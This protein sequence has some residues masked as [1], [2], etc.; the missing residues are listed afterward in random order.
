MSDN[1]ENSSVLSLQRQQSTAMPDLL[2]NVHLQ[3]EHHNVRAGIEVAMV[4]GDYL[5][6]HYL[7][8]GFD[9]VGWGCAYRSCQTLLS[10]VRL[11][12][13]AG[14]TRNA[15][16]P[17]PPQSPQPSSPFLP[18]S[19]TIPSIHELQSQLHAAG[20]KSSSF[21]GSCEWIG[22]CEVAL[23]LDMLD[24]VPCRILTTNDGTCV[25]DEWCALL[26]RHFNEEGTPVMVGGASGG[27]IA[28]LGISRGGTAGTQFL[29]LDPHFVGTVGDLD[30]ARRSRCCEWAS[31][32]TYF[33]AG[34]FYN[35]ALPL[36]SRR[37]MPTQVP[38]HPAQEAA[39]DANVSGGMDTEIETVGAGFELQFETV[40]TGY[41]T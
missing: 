28:I 32:A 21:V 33:R 10:H 36:L 4:R 8:D 9:D 40:E 20:D 15:R 31:P 34:C 29:F 39:V 37:Q 26:W 19:P 12:V 6:Y 35:C 16:S 5:W 1:T 41:G 30:G 2:R 38:S 3:L 23:L 25:E 11:A 13:S 14:A 24:G 7:C 17:P 18:P 27:A 22:S